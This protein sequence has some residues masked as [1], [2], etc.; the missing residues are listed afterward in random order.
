[1][2]LP[3]LYYHAHCAITFTPP[4]SVLGVS[5]DSTPYSLNDSHIWFNPAPCCTA[6]TCTPAQVTLTPLSLPLMPHPLLNLTIHTQPSSLLYIHPQ[7]QQQQTNNRTSFSY[8]SSDAYSKGGPLSVSLAI[9]CPYVTI[10]ANAST[11]VGIPIAIA[12][13]VVIFVAGIAYGIRQVHTH[14]HTRTHTHTHAHTHTLI[15][16][17]CQ[18]TY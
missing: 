13:A 18:H 2:S 11:D 5:I 10:N 12:L 16:T 14:A 15:D 3:V 7:L 6:S 8:L 9:E 4:H 1:M 17:P